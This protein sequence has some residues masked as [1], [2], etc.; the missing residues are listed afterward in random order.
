[1]MCE[2]A[3]DDHVIVRDWEGLLVMLLAFN[4]IVSSL[5]LPDFSD[6]NSFL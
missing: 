3:P 2:S 1:M 6:N 4:Q 5:V